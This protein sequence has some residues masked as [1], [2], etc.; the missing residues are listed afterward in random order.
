MKKLISITIICFVS[1]LKGQNNY[2]E[3]SKISKNIELIVNEISKK[4]KLDRDLIDNSGIESEPYKNFEK[5]KNASNNE[6]LTLT[7]HPNGVVRCYAFWALNLRP[8]INTFEIVKNH[9]NDNEKIQIQSGC[10]IDE[11]KVGDF[12]ISLVTPK[13]IDLDVNKLTLQERK[14]ID[15]LLIYNDNKLE[16]RNNAI[17]NAP[18]TLNLYTR[19]KKIYLKTHNQSALIKLAKYQKEKDISLILNNKENKSDKESGYRYTYVAIQN[20]PR[21]EFLPFLETRL[22]ETLDE[23]HF[24]YE[25]KE[26]YSAIAV[27]KD[28]KALELLNIPFTKIK[29]NNIKK[30][31]LDF[32]YDSILKNYD[33]IY[34]PILWKIWE[35]KDN[36]TIKGFKL[37]L[38][39][40]VKKAYQISVKKLG[41]SV[42]N[43]IFPQYNDSIFT[44]KLEEC[45][46]NF[47][48]LNDKKLADNIIEN[49][50]L[51]EGVS[52]FDIYTS[53]INKN[54]EIKFLD[55]LFKR[56]EKETNPYVYLEITKTLLKYDDEEVKNK[57]IATQKINNNLNEGWGGREF[58]KLLE[59]STK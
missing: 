22:K 39:N 4:N 59:E 1:T 48:L 47:V 24:S 54:R 34:L 43:E 30:Y 17:E 33:S 3:A 42:K 29:Y 8:N 18:E 9:L 37:Y 26:M 56:L 21:K 16:A 11:E 44:E 7:N 40:D 13:Y 50:I 19:L 46:L 52:N 31:H 14:K 6:L 51:K 38:K 57:I 58:K 20:F 32:I 49:K 41:E 5:L 25:W 2:Y 27:Y 53:Y 23:S 10:I 55:F 28:K 15:S 12:Y 45:M 36:I 35:E